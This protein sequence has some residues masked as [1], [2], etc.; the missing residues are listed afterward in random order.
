MHKSTYIL[1]QSAY[2]CAAYDKSVLQGSQRVAEGKASKGNR[3][4]PS[5]KLQ[6]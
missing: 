4:Y 2:A 6:T 3:G 1:I 5:R